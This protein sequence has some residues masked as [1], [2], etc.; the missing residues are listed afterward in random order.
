MKNYTVFQVDAFTTTP[1]KG[2]PAGVVLDAAGLSDEQMQKIAKELNNSETAFLFGPD[3]DT[4]DGVI[5]YF[6]PTVE[7]PTCGHATIASMYAKAV[8]ENIDNCVLRMKTGVGVLPFEIQTCD[9]HI[10]VWMTQGKIEISDPL[11]SDI[12]KELI[13]SLGLERQNLDH[14]CP[15]QIA[16]T[17]HSKV[18]VGIK[19]RENLDR[20]DPDMTGLIR[21][22]EQIRCNGYYVFTFD[23]KAPDILCHGR[24]FAPAIGINEDPV[25][26]NANGPLGAYLIH[27][28]IINPS[29]PA[30]HF[31]CIQGEA[32]GREGLIEVEVLL[33][34]GNPCLVRVG[35]QAVTVFKTTI[36]IEN[37]PL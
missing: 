30:F 7:V 19:S 37:M 29:G 25:T 5:R 10:K 24:M 1:F 16:S 22:G 23:S 13:T 32:M 4:C 8:E 20:L 2:N 28:D 26:G 14:R 21:L 17:G 3:D 18:M 33:E 12:Q 6:T 27:N 31:K 35:G 34:D 36:E 11:S 15:V 9:G